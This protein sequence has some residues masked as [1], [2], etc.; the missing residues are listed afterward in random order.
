VEKKMKMLLKAERLLLPVPGA[1]GVPK[2]R[3]AA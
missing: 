2:F 1:R 3:W